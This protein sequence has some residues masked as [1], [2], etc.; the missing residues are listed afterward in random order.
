MQGTPTLYTA[1]PTEYR[2]FLSRETICGISGAGV[3]D[4]LLLI[5]IGGLALIPPI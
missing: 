3:G 1:E 4:L 2:W 5:L